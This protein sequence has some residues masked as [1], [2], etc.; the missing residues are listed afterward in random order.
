MLLK[1]VKN[2]TLSMKFV[3][4]FLKNQYRIRAVKIVIMRLINIDLISMATKNL[5]I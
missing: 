3:F 4:K 1:N 2:M 5:K